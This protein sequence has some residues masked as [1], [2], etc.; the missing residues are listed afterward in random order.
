MTDDRARAVWDRL[1]TWCRVNIPELAADLRPGCTDD[2]LDEMERTIGQKLPPDVRAVYRQ[3]DGQEGRT[4]GLVYGLTM[5]PL[6][7]VLDQWRVWHDL[8]AEDPTINE[9]I[10]AGTS[11]PPDAIAVAYISDARIPLTYDGGG[12]HLGIDL[13]PGPAGTVGQIINFGADETN[14]YVLASS[15]LDFLEWLAGEYEAGRV[16]LHRIRRNQV[17]IVRR[18]GWTHFMDAIPTLTRP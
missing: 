16:E 5:L 9:A 8:L 12:N 2:E 7:R 14:K 3:H 1:L 11:H 13:A 6:N 10:G 17:T 15:L 4:P 18:P